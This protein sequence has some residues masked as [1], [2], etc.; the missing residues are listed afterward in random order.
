MA[1]GL[2][3]FY[4]SFPTAVTNAITNDKVPAGTTFLTTLYYGQ[5]GLT[6]PVQFTQVGPAVGFFSPGVFAG[7][8]RT[9]PGTPPFGYAMFQVRVWE[10]AYG[11]TYEQALMAPEQNGRFSLA[12]ESSIIRLRTGDGINGLVLTAGAIPGIV[13]TVV[14]E[15][16]TC[17][18]LLCAATCFLTQ[19]FA[20]PRRKSP[21]GTADNSP[22]IYRWVDQAREQ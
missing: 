20:K 1:Q 4:N 16:S 8:T 12:A 11:S 22:A 14:P 3:N 18:L 2:V 19:V 10:S 13:V 6:D 7:G 5:D 15:P 17:L 21:A 9:V